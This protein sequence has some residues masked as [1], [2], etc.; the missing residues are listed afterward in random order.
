MVIQPS[1]QNIRPELIRAEPE[2]L[3]IDLTNT[4]LILMDMQNAF[5]HKGGF[6]ELSGIDISQSRNIVEPIKIISDAARA[7]QVKVIYITGCYSADL[8][9]IGNSSQPCWYKDIRF[10]REHPEWRD[11]FVVHGTWGA[12]IIE[13]LEPQPGDII[14]EKPK[15]SAFFGTNLDIVLRTLNARYLIFVGV[16]TNI[17]VE[18]TIRDAYYRGYFPILIKDATACN[19]PQYTFDATIFNVKECY[20]WVT[21]TKDWLNVTSAVK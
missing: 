11:K 19:G 10:W 13:E 15:Y 3:Q 12:D 6:F 21:V 8:A 1:S 9:E 4:C 18:A 16:A 5:A 20:G 7:M 2:P 14:I 17:C